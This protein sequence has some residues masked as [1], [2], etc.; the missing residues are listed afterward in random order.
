MDWSGNAGERRS[1]K[2]FIGGT[3]ST[4]LFEVE[5]RT[6]RALIRTSF[7]PWYIMIKSS[8]K[9]A[10]QKFFLLYT[11]FGKCAAPQMRRPSDFAVPIRMGRYI[12]FRGPELDQ[13]Q[14]SP[15]PKLFPKITPTAPKKDFKP[16][17][18]EKSRLIWGF[19]QKL[20][21]FLVLSL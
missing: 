20:A 1:L 14:P 8:I 3:P 15:R 11:L 5:R 4:K 9:N 19:D 6:L 13:R 16:N 2:L 21:T 12:D 18:S 7:P 17:F 10:A